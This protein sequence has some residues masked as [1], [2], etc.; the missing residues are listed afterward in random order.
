MRMERTAVA[1]PS[2]P[3]YVMLDAL[4]GVAAVMVAV[5]H[6][7]ETHMALAGGTS[8]DTLLNHTYL[9]VDFFF[10]LSGFVLAYAYDDRR[11]ALP[12]GAFL[13]RRLIRLQP[14]VVLGGLLGAAVFYAHGA[15]AVGWGGIPET[16]LW[17]WGVVAVLGVLLLPVPKA[18]DIRGWGEMFPLN[19]VSWSLFY[20]YI[21]NVVYAVV[22]R[23]LPTRLLAAFVGAMACGAAAWLF[24]GPT[25]DLLRGWMLTPE[26][27]GVALLRLFLSFGLGLLLARVARPCPVRVP[28]WA[29]AVALVAY[30][31]VPRLGGAAHLWLNGLYELFGVLVVFPLIVWLGAGGGL[32]THTAREDA[33]CRWLGDLS[34]PLYITHFPFVLTY[35]AIVANHGWCSL[36]QAW[37]LALATVVATLLFAHLAVRYYDAP[38][39]RFLSARLARPARDCARLK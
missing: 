6:I 16:P 34:Y 14:M 28:F 23:W 10:L 32:H 38:F 18:L 25:G 8:R 22:L 29:L 2:K 26:H 11:A 9:A 31:A 20:E 24:L 13:R 35:T 1:L 17:R 19:A 37:P 21:G 5:F 12:L 3:H 30:F 36:G 39:R 15:P 4:R 27:V 33:L 7:M